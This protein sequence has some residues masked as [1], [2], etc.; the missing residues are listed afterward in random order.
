MITE[1]DIS[2]NHVFWNDT[3]P[4]WDQ[5]YGFDWNIERVEMAITDLETK[6]ITT[7]ERISLDHIT[8]GVNQI[9]NDRCQITATS[10][11]LVFQ[12]HDP[13]GPYHTRFVIT[14]VSKNF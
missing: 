12:H 1:I 10:L 3:L 14:L 2:L 6:K 4:I 13:M 11:D 7:S 9:T 5:K 8:K